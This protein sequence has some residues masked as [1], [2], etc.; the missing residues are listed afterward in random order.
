MSI[1][2]TEAPSDESDQA[3]LERRE[4]GAPECSVAGS[5]TSPFNS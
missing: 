4:D 5:F 1:V 3:R 2:F